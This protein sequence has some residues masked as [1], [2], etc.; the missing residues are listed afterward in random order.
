MRILRIGIEAQ[1]IRKIRKLHLRWWHGTRSNMQR[2]LRLAGVLTKSIELI[3]GVIDTCRECRAWASPLP[4][5]TPAVELT[6][7]QNENVEADIMYYKKESVTGFMHQA[8]WKTVTWKR[9]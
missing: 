2:I 1:V 7:A 9:F 3:P 8:S 4:D 6:T 5:V